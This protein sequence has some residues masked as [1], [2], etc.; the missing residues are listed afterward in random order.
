MVIESFDVV[1]SSFDIDPICI[2]FCLTPA[3]SIWRNIFNV[4]FEHLFFFSNTSGV[5]KMFCVIICYYNEEYEEVFLWRDSLFSMLEFNLLTFY[6]NVVFYTFYFNISVISHKTY[7]LDTYL[8]R[9]ILSGSWSE[10]CLIKEENR[11]LLLEGKINL[12]LWHKQINK[13]IIKYQP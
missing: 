13:S 1:D 12:T 6:S 3:G 10:V 11:N 9:I 8:Y 2:P 7:E 4:Y 5:L